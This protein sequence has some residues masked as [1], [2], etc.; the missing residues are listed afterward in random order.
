M[1]YAYMT[2][3]LLVL[4]PSRLEND[5]MCCRSFIGLYKCSIVLQVH[6]LPVDLRTVAAAAAGR[7]CP[8]SLVTSEQ[9]VW[10]H[11][12]YAGNIEAAVALPT[13]GGPCRHGHRTSAAAWQRPQRWQHGARAAAKHLD[14]VALVQ[15]HVRRAAGRLGGIRASGR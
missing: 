4:P 15:Q 12:A 10:R 9:A 7:K 5:W 11:A 14:V 8:R 2:T 3:A 13:L 1:A 6:R